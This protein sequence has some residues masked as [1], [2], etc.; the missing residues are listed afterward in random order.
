M[1]RPS[2]L[3]RRI[4]DGLI[5]VGDPERATQQQEY[6]RSVLPYA[7]VARPELRRLQRRW[8]SDVDFVD[9]EAW[10]AVIGELWHGAQ[11]REEW[12]A[13]IG[14]AQDRRFRH[15]ADSPDALPLYRELIESGAWWDVV[16]EIS[17]HLVGGVLAANP[18]VA[19]TMRAWSMAA[20]LWVRR[21]AILSQER[22]RDP[23]EQLLAEVIENNLANSPHGKEFFIRKAIGWALRS[24][25]KHGRDAAAWVRSF[26]DQHADRLAPLSIREA[27]KYL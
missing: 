12:Y 26:V 16:D 5:A 24:H 7:G 17:Q 13:A 14:L 8:F 10:R 27:S 4:R 1:N 9:A 19:D 3:Q 25:S 6:M 23:D 20:A 22:H 2:A 18:S 21:S 15:W 11:F